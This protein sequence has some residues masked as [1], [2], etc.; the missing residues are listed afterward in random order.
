[1]AEYLLDDADVRAL[2]DQQSRSRVTG[3]V[4]PG[5]ADLRL[6]E[7]HLPDPSI[8]GALDRPAAPSGEHEIVVRP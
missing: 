5:I 6:S 7:D 2:L 4:N 3:I 1:V 8:L